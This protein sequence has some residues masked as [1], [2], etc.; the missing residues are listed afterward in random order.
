[1]F[2]LEFE[3][4]DEEGVNIAAERNAGGSSKAGYGGGEVVAR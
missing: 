4:G 3:N 1:M 2:E